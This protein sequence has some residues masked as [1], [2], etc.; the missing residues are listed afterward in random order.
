MNCWTLNQKFLSFKIIKS[1]NKRMKIFK[2]DNIKKKIIIKIIETYKQNI[3][4]NNYKML[5]FNIFLC[6]TKNKHYWTKKRIL[7]IKN[8]YQDYYDMV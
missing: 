2:K 3:E 6:L 1:K 5:N 7:K 8:I 4:K